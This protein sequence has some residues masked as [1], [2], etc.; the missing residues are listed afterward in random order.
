MSVSESTTGTSPDLSVVVP[1][2]NRPE[3]LSRCLE[4]LSRQT[5]G[6]D[7]F[8][9]IVVDD[10]GAASLED[11]IAR[12]GDT[13]QVRLLRQPNAGPAAARNAGASA[14]R[15]RVLAFTDDDCVP[16]PGWLEHMRSAWRLHPTGLIGGTTVNALA[17]NVFSE[18]SQ[19]LVA[20]LYSYH[21]AA[22]GQPAFFTSNNMALARDLF[23]EGPFDTSFRLAAGE[24]REFCDRWLAR[25]RTLHFAREAVIH[26]YHDLDPRRY[27]R[28]H[29][30]YGRGAFHF[31]VARARRSGAV[32]LEPISFYTG[33]LRFPLHSR[34]PLLRRTSLSFWLGVSQAA[35][36]AGYFYEKWRG[37]RTA[38]S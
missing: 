2:F 24:D 38:G 35:N 10:G 37:G 23:L 32:R 16:G 18:A 11:V 7:A 6:R 5:T 25:G 17:G 4:G 30:N 28:Q 13:L 27:W 34:R 31:H 33:L 22:S 15:G 14:A 12:F 21:D 8:E 1:T 9:V 29:F 36:A 3:R 19:E 20:Y 26:H